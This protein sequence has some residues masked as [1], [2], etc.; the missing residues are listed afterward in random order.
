M[1]G[2]GVGNYYYDTSIVLYYHNRHYV[3]RGYGLTNGLPF[4]KQHLLYLPCSTLSFS[5]VLKHSLLVLRI[6]HN[7]GAR[8]HQIDLQTFQPLQTIMNFKWRICFIRKIVNLKRD[9]R[10]YRNVFLALIN[11]SQ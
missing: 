6:S 2:R 7:S 3:P 8:K 10:Q 5:Q 1:T 11:T 4:K 9:S